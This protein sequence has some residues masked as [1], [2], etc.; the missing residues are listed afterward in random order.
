M[1]GMVNTIV[2]NHFEVDLNFHPI[3]VI[4]FRNSDPYAIES[5]QFLLLTGLKYNLFRASK[6]RQTFCIVFVIKS[7]FLL[8]ASNLT[9]FI[10][11]LI[12]LSNLFKFKSLK[13]RVRSHPFRPSSESA[14]I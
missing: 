3:R 7:I 5:Q 14:H 12:S 1:S 4:R 9:G 2:K 13:K 6:K 11:F 8:N 10:R